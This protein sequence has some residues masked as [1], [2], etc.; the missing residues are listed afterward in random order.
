MKT[1]TSKN[2]ESTFFKML[3]EK[4]K[5]TSKEVKDELRK[6]GFYVFQI[7]VSNALKSIASDNKIRKE[8]NGQYFLYIKD[9]DEKAT[10]KKCK[11]LNISTDNDEFLYKVTIVDSDDE[12]HNVLI[13]L[14]EPNDYKYKIIYKNNII[15]YVNSEGFDLSRKQ[16][17]Y[18]AF[19]AVKEKFGIDKYF[20]INCR[21]K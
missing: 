11:V 21:K 17:R 5:A 1:L 12:K 19:I 13:Y 4:G 2:I 18:Y 16:S 15:C 3:N 7:T 9:I 8:Y 20:N 14:N 10:N 6:Q